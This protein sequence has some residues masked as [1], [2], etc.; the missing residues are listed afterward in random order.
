[1]IRIG[2]RA[3]IC[4]DGKPLLA[5][6]WDGYPSC[7]GLKLLNCDKTV[8]AIVNVAKEHTIDAADIAIL[9]ALNR[10]RIKTLTKKH[11]LTQA[12]IKAG[13]RRGCVI[14]AEDYQIGSIDSYSDWAEYQY[15]VRGQEVYFR[16]LSGF[17]PKSVNKASR[18]KL[19]KRL[20]KKTKRGDNG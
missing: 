13:K 11:R 15:D 9:E 17:Y 2:T 4:I 18:F 5:T 3:L 12:E 8:A 20:L 7:L 6:H 10:H 1:V 16:P 14:C 19:L